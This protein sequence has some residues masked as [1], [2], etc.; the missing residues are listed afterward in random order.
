MQLKELLQYLK[1]N[2]YIH[3][4]KKTMEDQYKKGGINTELVKYIIKYK[5]QCVNEEVNKLRADYEKR[6]ERLKE[7]REDGFKGEIYREGQRVD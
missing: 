1:E 5:D 4:D 3:F 6:M 2:V 7:N